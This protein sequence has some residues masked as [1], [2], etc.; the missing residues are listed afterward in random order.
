MKSTNSFNVCPRC[1]TANGLNARFCYQCGGALKVPEEPVACPRCHTVN[2][3]LAN[4][5]RSCGT[6]LKVGSA[7]KICPRCGREV[8]SEDSICTCGYKFAT[9]TAPVEAKPSQAEQNVAS[10]HKGARIFALVSLLLTVLFAYFLFAPTFVGIADGNLIFDQS[11]GQGIT[12]RPEFLQ[13]LGNGL[14]F[15][16]VDGTTADAPIYGMQVVAQIV[17]CFVAL[18]QGNS[19]P[20]LQF[21]QA[22]PVGKILL[23]GVLALTAISLVVQL[24]ASIVRLAIGKRPKKPNTWY[25]VMFF[26]SGLVCAFVTCALYVT[27]GGLAPFFQLFAV[28]GVNMSIWAICGYYLVFTILSLVAKTKQSKTN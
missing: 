13:V 28:E 8:F 7:S 25:F 21:L 9:V 20:I 18:A 2:T 17:G 11:Q 14:F 4:F 24:L 22:L 27:E 10:K 1:G 26:I 23:F 15:G 3:G 6:A 12:L 16:S 19:E 5:C